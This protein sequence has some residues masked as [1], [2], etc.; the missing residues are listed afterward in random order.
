MSASPNSLPAVADV[1]DPDSDIDASTQTL[2]QNEKDILMDSYNF[3]LT[4]LE[5]FGADVL[6]D[7]LQERLYQA[8]V[9]HGASAARS[10]FERKFGGLQADGDR[11]V[12]DRIHSGF[13]GY[14]SWEGVSVTAGGTTDWIDDDTPDNLSGTG[15]IGNPLTVGGKA[16]HV[17]LGFASYAENPKSTRINYRVNDTPRPSISTKFEWQYSDYQIKL[18]EDP[19]LLTENGQLAAELYADK[20]GNEDPALFGVSYIAQQDSQLVDPANMTGSTTSENILV[21]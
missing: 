1:F 4:T 12:I 16:V 15:G 6:V 2:S 19:L 3:S 11:F 18:L 17:I 8:A 20:D 13:F 14:D 5:E 9:I 7:K 21:D 10:Q